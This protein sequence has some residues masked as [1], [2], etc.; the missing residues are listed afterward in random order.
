MKGCYEALLIHALHT[1]ITLLYTYRDLL[2]EKARNKY[3]Y[4]IRRFVV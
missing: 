4:L 2:I 1:H 3:I